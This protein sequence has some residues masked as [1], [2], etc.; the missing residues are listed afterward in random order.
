MDLY[1]LQVLFIFLAKFTTVIMKGGLIKKEEL[2][3]L[4]INKKYIDIELMKEEIIEKA[5]YLVGTYAFVKVT[6]F[7]IKMLINYILTH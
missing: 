3:M 1:I 4:K 2:A 7:L 5:I 6:L